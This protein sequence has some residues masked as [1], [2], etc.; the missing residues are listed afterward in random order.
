MP[1]LCD[2]CVHFPPIVSDGKACAHCNISDPFTSCYQRRE[3]LPQTN[4]DRLRGLTDEEL[5][6]IIT[7]DWCELLD[8]EYPCGG[9]CNLKMLEWLKSPVK[10]K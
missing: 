1:D 6:K 7:G 10:V 3:E 5:A 2:T 4:G 9:R 8:C